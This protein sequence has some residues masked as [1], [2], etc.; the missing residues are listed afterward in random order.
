MDDLRLA[1]PSWRA[2]RE[3]NPEALAIR[4]RVAKHEAEAW[5]DEDGTS[6]RGAAAEGPNDPEEEEEVPTE[7]K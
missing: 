1:F 7:W 5:K 4:S 6:G 2:T 3:E